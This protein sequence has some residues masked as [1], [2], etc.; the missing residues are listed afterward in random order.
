MIHTIWIILAVSLDSIFVGMTYGMRQI[1]V[2]IWSMLLILCSS[3]VVLMIAFLT[4]SFLE[5]IIP[6]IFLER[7]GGLIFIAMAFFS[8]FAAKQTNHKKK[9]KEVIH[10]SYVWEYLQEPAKVDFDDSGQI[11]GIEAIFLSFALSLDAFGAGMAT[12]LSGQSVIFIWVFIPIMTIF[13]LYVGMIC[14]KTMV[15]FQWIMKFSFLP[16]LLFLLLGIM[17]L[18]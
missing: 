12:F 15:K 14:G 13:L 18:I 10:K 5:K 6:S 4:G 17:R 11:K 16:S 9:T 3:S 8:F 1:R 7:L 2:P